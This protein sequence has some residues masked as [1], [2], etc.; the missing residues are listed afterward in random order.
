LPPLRVRA[1]TTDLADNRLGTPGSYEIRR[2]LH[3]G[4]EQ[5]F[6]TPSVSEL[7]ELYETYYNFGGETGTRYTHWRE[8]FLFSFLYR[9]W[10]W[11]DGDSS[12]D[13]ANAVRLG[14]ACYVLL[15]I[16]LNVQPILYNRFLY[17]PMFVF[18]RFAVHALDPVEACKAAREPL[19]HLPVPSIQATP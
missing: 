1:G 3:C 15:L 6:P 2:C 16:V 11:L 4:L 10:I 12:A 17:I 7:K 8:R 19:G 9:V 5:T 14:L 18:A 13:S